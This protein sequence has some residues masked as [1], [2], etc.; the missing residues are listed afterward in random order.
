MAR[1]HGCQGAHMFRTN[2]LAWMPRSAYVQDKR[3]GMDGKE[4]ICSGRTAWRDGLW[5]SDP[6]SN[7]II[8][9]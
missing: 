3:A 7:L 1:W 4:R 9:K 8:R 5:H 6:Q 2:V